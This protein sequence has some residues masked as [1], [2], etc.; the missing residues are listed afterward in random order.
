MLDSFFPNRADLKLEIE[1]YKDNQ[2]IFSVNSK[3]FGVHQTTIKSWNNGEERQ[4][5]S[6]LDGVGPVDNRPSTD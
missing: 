2:N 4:M 3:E 1:I 5:K 6:K